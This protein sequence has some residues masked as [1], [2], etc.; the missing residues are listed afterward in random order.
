MFRINKNGPW[1]N[2][3][4]ILLVVSHLLIAIVSPVEERSGTRNLEV[5]NNLNNIQSGLQYSGQFHHLLHKY[6]TI[7]EQA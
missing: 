3:R 6:Q 1:I 4:S 7:H 5:S 2:V